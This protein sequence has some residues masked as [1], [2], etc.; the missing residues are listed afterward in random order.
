RNVRKRLAFTSDAIAA[1]STAE[2]IFIAVGTPSRPSDGH[3]D[4]SQVYAAVEGFADAVR[5]GTTIATKSTVPVGT[6]DAIEALLG[7]L[8]PDLDFDVASNPEFLRAG[9]AVSDFIHPDRVVIGAGSDRAATMLAE[10]YRSVGIERARI[11]RTDLRSAELIKYAA[12][13][14]LATKIAFINEISDLCEQVN[15]SIGDVARGIG[16]DRRIGAQYLEPGPG[17]GGSCFPKDARALAKVGEDF[18]APMRIIE[19][20][21]ASN[22]ARK[23]AMTRKIA[24]VHDGRLRG[25]TIALLGLSFKAETDDMRESVSIPLSQGLADAGCLVKAYDPV[26]NHRARAVLPSCVSY[27]GSALEA[28]ENADAVVIVT[29][30]SEFRKLDLRRLR[31]TMRTPLIVDLRNLL[32]E[33]EVRLSGFRYFRIGGSSPR[34]CA[35]AVMP[36]ILGGISRIDSRSRTKDG[37]TELRVTAAE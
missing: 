10:L 5:P 6:G 7:D 12:N 8:R 11:L 19:T 2:I 3:A 14:F 29:E 18:G 33:S 36:A 35:D 37:D 20:V 15:A 23:R 27:H 21:L 25:K 22:D 4:L 24:R 30:W 16:L 13:G 26:A 34:D 17:F 31:D 9:S 32:N 28:A 1:V